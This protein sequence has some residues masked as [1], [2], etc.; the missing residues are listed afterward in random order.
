MI[1]PQKR[2]NDHLNLIYFEI[3]SDFFFYL[4]SI[5]TSDNFNFIPFDY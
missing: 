1:Q 5:I 2:G 4:E 3:F